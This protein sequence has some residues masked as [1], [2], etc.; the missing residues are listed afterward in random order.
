MRPL[1]RECSHMKSKGFSLIEVLVVMAIFCFLLAILM[2]ILSKVLKKAREYETKT[3]EKRS[4]PFLFM[5]TED[6]EHMGFGFHI[7]SREPI[8][9]TV[10]EEL[11]NKHIMLHALGFQKLRD[12]VAQNPKAFRKPQNLTEKEIELLEACGF[13]EWRLWDEET[14]WKRLI[15][16]MSSVRPSSVKQKAA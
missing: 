12:H 16:Q 6:G 10:D 14:D 9:Y 3:Y 7:R 2:P 5:T 1:F 15:K 11:K 13:V 4:K 8:I